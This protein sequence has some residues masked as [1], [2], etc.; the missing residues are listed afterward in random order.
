MNAY[1]AKIAARRARLEERAE[2]LAD[3]ASSTYQRARTERP[4]SKGY[5]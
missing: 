5:I 1:E 4:L 2:K 3:E